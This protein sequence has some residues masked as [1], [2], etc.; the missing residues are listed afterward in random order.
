MNSPVAFRTTLLMFPSEILSV[1]QLNKAAAGPSKA[2][3][4]Q[5]P[6]V[7][8][9]LFI[10]TRP[11]RVVESVPRCLADRVVLDVAS[12]VGSP[13]TVS[14]GAEEDGEK[15]KSD[16]RVRE[17]GNDPSPEESMEMPLAAVQLDPSY[18]FK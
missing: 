7:P 6:I 15:T 14:E 9:A 2:G 18:I 16:P 12:N 17:L 10:S 4:A 11:V 5:I 8:P 1:D 3:L 13:S